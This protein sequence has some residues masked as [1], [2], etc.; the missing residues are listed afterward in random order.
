MMATKEF[1]EVNTLFS[2]TLSSICSF[3]KRSD[4]Q[5]LAIDIP[6]EA[7]Q[8]TGGRWRSNSTENKLY[9]EIST[10]MLFIQPVILKSVVV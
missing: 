9:G 4:Y 10:R 3:T 5:R 6:R 8:R 2:W 1:L 7:E